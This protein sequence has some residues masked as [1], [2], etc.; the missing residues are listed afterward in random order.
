LSRTL[1]NTK[2]VSLR[3][4]VFS[5]QSEKKPGKKWVMG[6]GAFD[7]FDFGTLNLPHT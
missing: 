5:R 2:S 6:T 7:A 4:G 3:K 1:G